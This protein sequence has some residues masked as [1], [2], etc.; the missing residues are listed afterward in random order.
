[1]NREAEIKKQIAKLQEELIELAN[2][3]FEIVFSGRSGWPHTARV[4]S[5]K[6]SDIIAA[7]EN[8]PFL[9]SLANQ[10]VIVTCN[11]AAY[12]HRFHVTETKSYS[13]TPF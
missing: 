6:D 9:D 4:T 13:V 3:E 10:D 7:I 2:G 1:M 12:E 5:L 8:H 11:R